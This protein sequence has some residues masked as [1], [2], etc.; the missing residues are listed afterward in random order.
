MNLT[1]FQRKCTI[2]LSALFTLRMLQLTYRFLQL[3]TITQLSQN[4]KIKP[5]SFLRLSTPL[6]KNKKTLKNL[7][8]KKS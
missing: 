2:S 6:N 5:K 4:L 7:F 3:L 8:K 1:K